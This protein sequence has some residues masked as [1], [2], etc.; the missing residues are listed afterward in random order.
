MFLTRS[1]RYMK[2]FICNV[3]RKVLGYSAAGIYVRVSMQRFRTV[4][5]TRKSK[6]NLFY[7]QTIININ[8]IG[9]PI[10]F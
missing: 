8:I 7:F 9:I 10:M 5:R 1:S 2:R 3:F 6:K 4:K